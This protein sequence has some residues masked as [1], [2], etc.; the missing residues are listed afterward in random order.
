VTKS[1]FGDDTLQKELSYARKIGLP[2]GHIVFSD[3]EL[4]EGF[5]L[6]G[7]EVFLCTKITE[8]KDQILK[9]MER[10]ENGDKEIPN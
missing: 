5:L 1:Y 7:E 3:V 8:V 10:I 6:E 9:W 4:P 2:V